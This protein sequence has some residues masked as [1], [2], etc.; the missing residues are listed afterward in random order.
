MNDKE[1][2]P[3]E[4][5]LESLLKDDEH[6]FKLIYQRYASG[7]YAAAYNLFRNKPLCEDLIQELFADLWIKRKDLNIQSLKPY[8]YMSV[9][10]RVLML[11][12]SG[13]AMLDE[14]ALEKLIADYAADDRLNIREL[15]DV[16]NQGIDSLPD[17]C[18]EIFQLSRREHLSNKEIAERLNISVKTVENQMTI[19]LRRLREQAGEFLA[20]LIIWTIFRM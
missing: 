17:R 4:T 16:L 18:R 11:I 3:D 2:W 20:I 15:N 9:K 1:L 8:L 13:R 12:R 19:A 6:A 5:L 10:N 7:L 14:S